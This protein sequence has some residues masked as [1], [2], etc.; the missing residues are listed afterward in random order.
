MPFLRRA[1]GALAVA[2][3]LATSVAHAETGEVRFTRQPGLIYM[4]MV[5]AEQQRLVEKH[6]ASA[7][8]GDVKVS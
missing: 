3:G 2:L 6:V 1:A 8:L 5:L 7:G 4:P